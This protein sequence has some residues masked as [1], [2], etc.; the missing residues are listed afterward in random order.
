MS[1]KRK[2]LLEN[3]EI[4]QQA[5]T[6]KPRPFSYSRIAK[7]ISQNGY[8]VS[9]QLVCAVCKEHEQTRMK[10]GLKALDGAATKLDRKVT[11]LD[12]ATDRIE[13]AAST[14]AETAG[15]FKTGT[16]KCPPTKRGAKS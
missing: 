9:A 8:K 2:F 13:D 1:E 14:L 15:K 5:R 4:I 16:K 12:G 11:K 10:G 3:F 7:I 6:R